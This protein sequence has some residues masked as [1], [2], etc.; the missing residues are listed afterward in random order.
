V[1]QAGGEAVEIALAFS[2]VPSLANCV[3]RTGQVIEP[4]APTAIFQKTTGN[5]V[6]VRGRWLS[7]PLLERALKLIDG[8][9]YWHVKVERGDGTLDRATLMVGLN[10]ES[11][12]QNPMWKSRIREAVTSVTAVRMD[13]ECYLLGEDDPQPPARVED[14][15][16]HHSVDRKASA[17]DG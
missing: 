3:I 15:R 16:L 12:V 2:M 1:V 14:L 6:L 7:L 11:L 9:S 5:H 8:I 10:R 4:E 13:I 17:L